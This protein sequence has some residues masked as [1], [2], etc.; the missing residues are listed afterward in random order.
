MSP[1]Q[2]RQSSPSV[3]GKF[4]DLTRK[5]AFT[6]VP[7]EKAAANFPG[8]VPG[9]LFFSV[10]S[11]PFL[12]SQRLEALCGGGDGVPRVGSSEYVQL[13]GH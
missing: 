6:S 3:F 8:R 4:W 9:P 13:S 11:E 7:S 5:L 1:P 10:D 2:L 12:G